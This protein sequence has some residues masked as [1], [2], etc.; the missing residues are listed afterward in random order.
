MNQLRADGAGGQQ[1]HCG[2]QH[3]CCDQ[4][5]G[6]AVGSLMEAVAATVTAL[7]DRRN[8]LYIIHGRGW[9][10][11]FCKFCALY[12]LCVC[13]FACL[14]SVGMYDDGCRDEAGALYWTVARVRVIRR[15]LVPKTIIRSCERELSE[16]DGNPIFVERER[17]E[18]A[19]VAVAGRMMMLHVGLLMQTR[20]TH[21]TTT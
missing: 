3:S 2:G 6:S 5:H 14:C 12:V 16:R 10:M 9:S 7:H 13:V 8:I 18:H 19:T 1:C 21:D 4:G 17:T 15:L 11:G 20:T